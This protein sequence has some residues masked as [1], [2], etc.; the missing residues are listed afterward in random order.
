MWIKIDGEQLEVERVYDLGWSGVQQVNLD[1]GSEWI[2]AASSEDAGAAA[3]ER[4]EDMA[5]ND[6]SEFRALIG[7]DR[8]IAWALGESDSYGF[9]SAEDFFSAVERVPEEEWGSYDG[10]EVDVQGA[11]K[12][13]VAELGFTPNVAYRH[14]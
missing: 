8:L 5:Q 3:R 13:L 1:D 2:V 9:E 11:S 7:D 4:W 14:N 12:D 6:K 10:N